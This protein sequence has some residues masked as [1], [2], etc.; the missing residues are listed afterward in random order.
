M[1]TIWSVNKEV[2][3][4]IE[5]YHV[6]GAEAIINS[7]ILSMKNEPYFTKEDFMKMIDFAYERLNEEV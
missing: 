5:K 4:C 7:V 3:E 6:Y 2:K 1:A